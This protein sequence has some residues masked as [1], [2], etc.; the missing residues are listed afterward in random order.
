MEHQPQRLKQALENL[1]QAPE[2]TESALFQLEGSFVEGEEQV[3]P[4]E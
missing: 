2:E 4:E 3:R 1:R